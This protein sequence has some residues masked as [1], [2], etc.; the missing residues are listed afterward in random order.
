M[1]RALI[2]LS[3]V[4]VI[5]T[6]GALAQRGAAA[7]SGLVVDSL[8]TPVVGAHV[9]IEGTSLGATTDAS[10][11]FRLS[12][13]EAGRVTLVARRIGFRPATL[14]LAVGERGA[15]QIMVTMEVVAEVLAP[16]EVEAKREVY[17]ARLQGF[18]ERS[19]RRTS[20]HFVGRERI[21]RAHSKRFVDILREVP[22]VRIVTTRAW[23]TVVYLRG[24]QCPPVVYIDGFPANAGPMDLDMIDLSSV[25]GIEIYAGM[26]SVPGEFSTARTDLCGVIAV[27]SRPAR[28]A[29]RAPASADP[30]RDGVAVVG[31]GP[32]FMPHA[33]DTVAALV[34][35]SLNPAYP[36][37]LLQAQFGG[38]VLTRFVVDTSGFVEMQTLEII[39]SAH[40]LFADAAL[41]ALRNAR[42]SPAIRMGRRV[43]QIVSL[44]FRFS[45]PATR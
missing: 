32:A 41:L 11:S 30:S 22:S 37:S 35:S 40:R 31:S 39:D 21:E 25:E 29:L 33:V 45:P 19:A 27:W 16:V 1:W 34:Q 23:G 28:P 15:S 6:R 24:A 3:A 2:G 5:G 42:F 9:G 38:T 12:G 26:G 4:L 13:V 36:D 43:R 17:D 18:Q 10:G 20:G 7:L 8:G 14:S 44:P